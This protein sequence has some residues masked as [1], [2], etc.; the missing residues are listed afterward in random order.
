MWSIKCRGSKKN[1]PKIAI[2]R[3]NRLFC[4]PA[5]GNLFLLFCKPTYG[6]WLRTLPIRSSFAGAGPPPQHGSQMPFNSVFRFLRGKA[7]QSCLGGRGERGGRKKSTCPRYLLTCCRS[8]ESS[9]RVLLF[10]GVLRN[11]RS[12]AVV[13]RRTAVVTPRAPTGGYPPA[14]PLRRDKCQIGPP[15]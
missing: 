13:N 3:I 2:N 7:N 10:R 14:P 4:F 1:G 9:R 6:N 5:I 15:S 11:L 8:L 12:V